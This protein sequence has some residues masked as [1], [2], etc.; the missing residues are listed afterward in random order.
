MTSIYRKKPF[1]E[2]HV[3][4]IWFEQKYIKNLKTPLGE[5]IEVLSPGIWNAEAG[6]DFLKAHIKVNQIDI[7]GDIEIHTS[8]DHWFHHRHHL[9]KNFNQVILHVCLFSKPSD[10]PTIREDSKEVSTVFLSPF[11][12]IPLEKIISQ[13]DLELYPYKKLL[14]NGD[15]AHS[16]FRHLS[17]KKTENLLESKAEQRLIEKSQL[18]LAKSETNTTPLA[19]GVA[20]ALGYK[21]N[22]EAFLELYHYL[23][24]QSHLTE[25]EL[26][27][28]SLH[29]TR[30]FEN[31]FLDKW[32]DSS[33]YLELK[34]ISEQHP[35]S[36]RLSKK[37]SLGSL[38]PFNHPV[39]RIASL[40]KLVKDPLINNYLPQIKQLWSN[41]WGMCS[42][43]R[44]FSKLK[45]EL[46]LLLPE[47]KDSYW[48]A[49]FT[50][51]AKKN[52]MFL[53]L[54][55]ADLKLSILLNSVFPLLFTSILD[56]NKEN[57]DN[58]QFQS[59]SNL[60]NKEVNKEIKQFLTLF[61]SI[62]ASKNS[63]SKYLSH[64]F[65]GDSFNKITLEKSIFEQGAYQVHKSYCQFYESSCEGCPFVKEHHAL[66]NAP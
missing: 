17:C 11:L 30:F 20:M 52:E 59:Q 43:K 12:I 65:F 4:A 53:S 10:K 22:T 18:L 26:F 39:R 50:F 27:A 55:G 32:K 47:Y 38:R 14:G 66:L 46:L 49:H 62:S 16:F 34:A 6:P 61:S 40:V 36:F 19:I 15:C 37:L 9:D 35:T 58:P 29:I 25:K 41:S 13:L 28:I 48:N 24:T 23:K 60:I 7:F 21:N 51:G 8:S 64:R 45:K 42:K 54:F 57:S 1:N 31:K 56:K 33:Y 2:K 44:D 63:K 5:S 3:Q